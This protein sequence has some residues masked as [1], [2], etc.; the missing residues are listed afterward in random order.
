MFKGMLVGK[1]AATTLIIAGTVLVVGISL[2]LGGIFPNIH[3][4]KPFSFAGTQPLTT[5]L[6]SLKISNTNANIGDTVTFSGQI[7]NTG[8]V[9]VTISTRARFCVTTVQQVAN[10]STATTYRVGTADVALPTYIAPGQS[11]TV[12]SS[13]YK[14]TGGDFTMT[15]CSLEGGNCRV[16]LFSIPQPDKSISCTKFDNM[17]VTT[18]TPYDPLPA[19]G[20]VRSVSYLTPLSSAGAKYGQYYGLDLGTPTGTNYTGI[21]CTVQFNVTAQSQICS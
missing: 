10:C 18:N 12:T 19:S 21:R 20:G 11:I 3:I 1:N 9:P 5:I 17:P 6:S 4:R 7:K 14:V 15:L 2:V 8:T 13:P 16:L